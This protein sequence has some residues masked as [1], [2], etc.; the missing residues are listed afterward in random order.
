MEEED[1]TVYCV[2]SSFIL[3]FVLPDEHN[4]TT[5]YYFE[6]FQNR[7]CV[8][9]APHILRLEVINAIKSAVIR[10]RITKNTASLLIQNFLH[11]ERAFE[12]PVESSVR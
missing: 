12:N 4:K 6:L 3:S 9:I 5:D 11:F 2:D 7:K 10:N 1:K 8:F